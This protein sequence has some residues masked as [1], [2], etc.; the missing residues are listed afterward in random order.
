MTK[1]QS[2]HRD[3]SANHKDVG[4]QYYAKIGVKTLSAEF[5]YPGKML[6]WHRKI[7]A[8]N[9]TPTRH[10]HFKT[11]PGENVIVTKNTSLVSAAYGRI[12]YTHDV[13]RDVMLINVLP[14]RRE[15]LLREDLWRYRTEHVRS[16]EENKHLCA[17]RTKSWFR[18]HPDAK[19]LVNPPTK[20]EPRPT[21]LSRHDAWENPSMP[22]V[23]YLYD[24]T[25]PL[26]GSARTRRKKIKE[27]KA[28][29]LWESDPVT[30]FFTKVPV[31]DP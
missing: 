12:K 25:T 13:T 15:E 18:T 20:P 28:K 24:E 30:D 9:P 2:Y 14:E 22:D 16:M 11:Y 31:R 10:R 3:A 26:A 23:P 7:I 5:A 8:F 1:T 6:A 27:M 17:L 4:Q 19:P 21:R 29:G